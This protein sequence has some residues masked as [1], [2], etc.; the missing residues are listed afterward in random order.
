MSW[1]GWDTWWGYWRD[2]SGNCPEC[3]K[4]EWVDVRIKARINKLK[5]AS[6]GAWSDIVAGVRRVVPRSP[7]Y[8]ERWGSGTE[9]MKSE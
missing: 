3:G 5:C 7:R 6:C 1:G 2:V 4:D 9:A 8:T